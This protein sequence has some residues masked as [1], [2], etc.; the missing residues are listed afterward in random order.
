MA[1]FQIALDQ[2]ADVVEIDAARTKD[3]KFFVFLPGME[4]PFLKTETP[5]AK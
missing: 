4:S 1:A 2:G 5:I 3:G